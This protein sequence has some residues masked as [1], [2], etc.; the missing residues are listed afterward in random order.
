MDPNSMNTILSLLTFLAG[1]YCLYA[2]FQ[3]R[4]GT[5]PEKFLLLSKELPADQCLDQEQYVRYLRPRLLIIGVATTVFGGFT[6]LN[7]HFA[8]L[9]RWCP[10]QA[11]VIGLLTS[12]ILPLAVVIWFCFCLNKIQRELW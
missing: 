1:L 5:I 10:E 11:F 2:W 7:D 12:S 9:E 8:L 6:L 3:L 4:K